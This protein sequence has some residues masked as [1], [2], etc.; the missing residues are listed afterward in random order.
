MPQKGLTGVRPAGSRKSKTVAPKPRSRK[1]NPLSQGRAWPRRASPQE[2]CLSRIACRM[3]EKSSVQGRRAMSGTTR[4]PG[5][6]LRDRAEMGGLAGE[7]RDDRAGAEAPLGRLVG[8]FA[9][10]IGR[11]PVLAGGA[12]EDAGEVEVAVL[13][14]D[15]EDAVAIELRQVKPDRFAGQEVRWDRIR[16]EGVKHDERLAAGL[17][18]ERDARVAEAHGHVGRAFGEG[19]EAAGVARDPQH[20]AVDLEEAPI[21]PG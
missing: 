18:G 2:R 6:V 8:G 11:K 3:S 17:A 5:G 12:G 20:R 9:H 4:W 13:D 14:V 21:L 1:G 10:D 7:R 15:D 19:A 16:G